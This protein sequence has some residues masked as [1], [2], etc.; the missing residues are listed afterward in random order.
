[1]SELKPVAK[2]SSG[3][4]VNGQ[5]FRMYNIQPIHGLES[6][7]KVGQF[8]FAIPEGYTIVPIEPTDKMINAAINLNFGEFDGVELIYKAMIEASKAEK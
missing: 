3:G 1:M 2:V 4:Y 8:L 7:L 6:N 5:S